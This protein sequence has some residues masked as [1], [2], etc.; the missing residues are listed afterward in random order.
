[1]PAA[2][3]LRHLLLALAA[4]AI[5]GTN[6][7]L[8]KVALA[9]VPPLLFGTLRFAFAAVPAVFFIRRPPVAWGNLA[10]YGLLIG[11]VQFGVMYFAMNGHVSPG[12]ASLVVQMQVFF[13]IGLAI[14]SAGER[15]AAFQWLALVLA[16][17][18]IAVIGAHTDGTTSVPGLALM[19]LAALGWAGGNVVAKRAGAVDMLG[20]VAWSSL[21]SVPVLFVLSLLLDGAEADLH[22]LRHGTLADWAA[23]LWQSVG[24]TLF[25]Y[26][27]WAWLLARHPAASI[28]PMA[29]LVPIFGMAT[30]AITLHEAMPGWKL[31]ATGLV[32]GGLAL[33]LLWPRWRAR[34]A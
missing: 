5:W 24:N 6:F 23:V 20:Y 11:V 15:V 12:I 19:L 2:L 30:A 29:L 33:N 32:L 34:R 13:T 25:G 18:G 16:V 31:G 9:H 7:A 14:V 21:F 1:M 8:I 10:A 26:G 17:A 3:P 28:A 27:A 4:V 22:W